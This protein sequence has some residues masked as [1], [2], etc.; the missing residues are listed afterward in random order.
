MKIKIRGHLWDLLAFRRLVPNRK[1]RIARSRALPLGPAPMNVL[2]GQLHPERQQLVIANIRDE[3]AT[4]KTFRLVPDADGGTRR[5]PYF[6]AGQYLSLRVRVDG[7]RIT[8]PYSISSAPFESLG[9]D[10]FYEITVRRKTDGFL[11]AHMWEK[12]QVGTRIQSSGPCGFFYHEP[13]RD[14][15]KIVGLAG[16]S[17]VTP[18]RSMARAIVHGGM[19]AELLLIYGSSDQGDILFYDELEELARQAPDRIRVVHVLSCEEVT[20]PGCEQGFITADIITKYADV[21]DS[22][23]FVC[24]PPIM[25]RFVEEELTTL[26]LPPWRIRREGYGEPEDVTIYPDFP[27]HLASETFQVTVHVG[28][29]TTQVPARANET[30][31]VALERANL[32]PPSHC[33]S[34][35][36]GFCRARLIQGDA[37]IIPDADGRRAADKEFGYLHICASYP[38]NDLELGV[39]RGP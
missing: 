19:E 37:Y 38:L 31:L 23:F 22:S 26:T 4:C 5:L 35:E 20:R 25:Y 24:G 33:R 12:W 6:R 7:V 10:G 21:G 1:R 16:G 13:I 27:S 9:E 30:L 28:G 17:G 34:G 3:T 29:L 18:F 15:H 32:A 36:C 14:A 2:A 11:T 8:R 39:A